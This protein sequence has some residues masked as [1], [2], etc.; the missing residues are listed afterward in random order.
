MIR[1]ATL[2]DAGKLLQIYSYYVENTAV[3]FEYT[4]PTEEEFRKR[5]QTTLEQ[6]PYLIYEKEG[7]IL[8]F[9]YAGALN[10]RAAAR[11]MVETSIYVKQGVSG[12]GIGKMLYQELET[13]LKKQNILKLVA[14]IADSLVTDK[15][16]TKQS[17]NFHKHMGYEMTGKISNA[18][19]K[20]DNWY[21]LVYMEKN[22]GEYSGKPKEVISFAEIVAGD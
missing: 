12:K 17:I 14:C 4:I 10:K 1:K 13:I 8:G 15:Y 21:D 22:I 11:W 9:V 16:I 19:Y 6:Y 3:T 2:E 20:F 18:G 7:E 5:I